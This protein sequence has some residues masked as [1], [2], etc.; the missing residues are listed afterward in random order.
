MDLKQ[1]LLITPLKEDYRKEL[2]EK[3]DSLTPVQKFELSDLCWNL[4]EESK[5]IRLQSLIEKHMVEVAEGKKKYD[6]NDIT[7]IETRVDYEFAQ[8]FK[9][10]SS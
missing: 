10:I 5:Q 2:L 1:L 4:L 6:Q 8:K 9:A 7:E 3:Y